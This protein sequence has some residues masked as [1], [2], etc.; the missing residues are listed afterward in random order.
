MA[1]DTIRRVGHPQPTPS[2]SGTLR[3]QRPTWPK[4]DRRATRLSTGEE[5]VENFALAVMGGEVALVLAELDEPCV[6]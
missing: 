5:L 6:R 1:G 2:E 4:Q 3:S